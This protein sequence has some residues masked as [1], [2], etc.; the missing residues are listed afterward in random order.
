MA[1]N[2]TLQVHNSYGDG[3][4]FVLA[5]SF[6]VVVLQRL[7]GLLSDAFLQED[8]EPRADVLLWLVFLIYKIPLLGLAPF[9]AEVGKVLLWL[10]VP[11]RI[12]K[13]V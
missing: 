1:L 8:G 12:A 5:M 7:L 9:V 11:H 3:L 6:V 13:T 2:G 4:M 10:C